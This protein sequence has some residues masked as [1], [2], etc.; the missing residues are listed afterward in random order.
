[1]RSIDLKNAVEDPRMDNFTCLLFRLI[2]KADGP[3]REKLA[4]G[5]PVE[6][7]M[8]DIFQNRCPMMG[9]VVSSKKTKSGVAVVN[10]RPA[11]EEI[12]RMAVEKVGEAE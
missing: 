9:D 12:E 3:N 1:M 10:E 8:A 5:Y 4:L 2:L 11:F 7:E 6:V